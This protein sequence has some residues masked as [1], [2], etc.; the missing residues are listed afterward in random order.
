MRILKIKHNILLVVNPT[1]DRYLIAIDEDGG[2]V[3]Q[4]LSTTITCN[5]AKVQERQKKS[6]VCYVLVP[7]WLKNNQ[8]I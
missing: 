2:T 3:I 8:Q 6:I 5:L 4:N 7:K 1:A